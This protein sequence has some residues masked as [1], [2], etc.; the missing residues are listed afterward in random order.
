MLDESRQEFVARFERQER[1]R[2]RRAAGR[3]VLDFIGTAIAAV[4][5]LGLPFVVLFLLSDPVHPL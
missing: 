5:V 1:A 4:L 2:R 3:T